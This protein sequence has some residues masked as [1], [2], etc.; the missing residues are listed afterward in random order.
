M[1]RDRIFPGPDSAAQSTLF[2]P[3]P[4]AFRSVRP[5]W[6]HQFHPTW[7]ERF[8]CHFYQRFPL[9]RWPGKLNYNSDQTV[10]QD[11]SSRFSSNGSGLIKCLLNQS[12]DALPSKASDNISEK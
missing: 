5:Q 1:L 3:Q 10:I 11:A 7:A 6:L 4:S 2:R 12:L 9:Q 8:E